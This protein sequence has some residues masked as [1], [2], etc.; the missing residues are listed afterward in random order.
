MDK[1]RKHSPKLFYEWVSQG[2]TMELRFL[3]DF[4]GVKFKNWNLIKKLSIELNLEHRYNSLYINSYE[5]CKK[6]L[7]Y[8]IKNYPLTRYYNI[9][10]GVN[11]RRKIFVISNNGLLTKSFYGGIAGTSHIQNILCDIEHIGQR[12]GNATEKMLDE[13]IDG[14]KYLVKI[15]N[16]KSYSINISGNGTHLWFNLEEPISLPIPAFKEIIVKNRKK[17]KY[18]LKELRIR[19]WIKT[20]NK[21]IE[22]LDSYLQ[23]YNPSLKVDDGAK[24]L[25]RIAR[26]PGSWNVK[27]NK[28]QRCVGTVIWDIQNINIINQTFTSVYTIKNK[29]NESIIK[30]AS[31]SRLYRY[32]LSNL[33]DC[34][35]VKLLLSRLL[36]SVL[37]RNHYLEQSLARILRDNNINLVDIQDLINEMDE[38]QEKTLQVDPDYLDNEEPFNSE[39]VNT[40]CIASKIDLVYPILGEIPNVSNTKD[41][42]DDARYEKLN[43][44]S[45]TTINAMRLQ[46]Y[47]DKAKNYIQLKS[48]IRQLIDKQYTRSVIFFTVKYL[49]KDDWAYYHKNR[50]I[51]QLLNKTRMRVM[52]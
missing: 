42:I 13:C 16:L 45:D 5:D 9:F 4:K 21:F 36:P 15:L 34:P 44:Y 48:L 27:K 19:R 26:M 14:A 46:Q 1:Y 50:I 29:S 40:Y 51:L 22:K 39:M 8:R 37:S 35:L 33:R 52:D 49:Y 12:V 38:V 18:D 25:S 20:Y 3:S 41:F 28:D 17:V 6:V 47:Q 43:N 11:P 10:L 24:D 32:N 2:R 7:L 30:T 31:K 23:E